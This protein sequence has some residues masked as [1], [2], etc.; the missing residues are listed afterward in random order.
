[1]KSIPAAIIRQKTFWLNRSLFH[2]EPATITMEIGC[3]S[4]LN[5]NE[6]D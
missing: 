2:G 1:M 6:L 5:F 3:S 4:K